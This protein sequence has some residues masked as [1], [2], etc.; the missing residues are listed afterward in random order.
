MHSPGAFF[1][2]IRDLSS[3]RWS[4]CDLPDASHFFPNMSVLP[5]E[6]DSFPD[7]EVWLCITVDTVRKVKRLIYME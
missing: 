2:A 4:T 1:Y 5:R 6:T 3:E 7:L